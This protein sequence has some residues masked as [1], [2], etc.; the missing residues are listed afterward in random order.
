MKQIMQ[1]CCL[2]LFFGMDSFAQ[3]ISGIGGELSIWGVKSNY[4]D[5]LSKKTGFEIFGGVAAELEDFTLNDFEAGFKFL[6]AM[7]YTRTDRTYIG[8]VGKYKWLNLTKADSRAGL[9][10]P[11][12][13][14]GKEWY[15]KRV[16]RKGVAVELGYQLASKEYTVPINYDATGRKTFN[17]FPLIVNLRYT[18][19]S[20]R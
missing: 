17:E 12:F 10:V 9:P 11:G 2:F 19:Y 15:S 6:H 16:R 18:F 4:R 20:K 8:L 3:S 13:I 5:W 1:I 14:V 7:V